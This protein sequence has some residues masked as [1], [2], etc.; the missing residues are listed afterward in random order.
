MVG[1]SWFFGTE[2]LTRKTRYTNLWPMRT[3]SYVRGSQYGTELPGSSPRCGDSRG[4]WAGD[5]P[6]SDTDTR[7]GVAVVRAGGPVEPITVVASN[8]WVRKSMKVPYRIANY[9]PVSNAG[10]K[11][12]GRDA[13]QEQ[14]SGSFGRNEAGEA[15]NLDRRASICLRYD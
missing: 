4:A 10:D 7:P 14:V 11:F 6:A 12:D 3:S 8:R 5:N 13:R 1:S 2:P 9:W 15:R